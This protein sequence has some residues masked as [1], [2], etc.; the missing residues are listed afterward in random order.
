MCKC[1]LMHRT[2]TIS[3]IAEGLRRFASPRE[4]RIW[5]FSS[6][7]DS[8][9][10]KLLV[11]TRL[12]TKQQQSEVLVMNRINPKLCFLLLKKK[13]SLEMYPRNNFIFREIR[14]YIHK[15][16]K[17]RNRPIIMQR[18]GTG[19]MVT[20]RE[21]AG[22]TETSRVTVAVAKSRLHKQ[23]DTEKMRQITKAEEAK[24]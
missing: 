17:L 12:H 4:T 1:T 22:D 8:G 14:S 16:K 9:R 18:A 11:I 20:M 19:E 15:L 13:K 3:D 2:S 23:D 7:M 6:A 21:G 10:Q 5:G 24:P